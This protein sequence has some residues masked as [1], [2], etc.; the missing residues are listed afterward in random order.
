MAKVKTITRK[1]KTPSVWKGSM[2]MENAYSSGLAG[3]KTLQA[4]KNDGVFLATR[5]DA[6]DIIYFPA[7]LYCERCFSR[8][9]ET[10]K[11]IGP[12]G[13]VESWSRVAIDQKGKKLSKPYHAVLIRLDGANTLLLHRL[14]MPTEPYFGLK[15]RPV[16]KE[17]DKR[18][19]SITDILCFKPL[20][21]N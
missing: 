6:C 17:Q 5:C 7:R 16:L 10:D 3:E 18:R 1:H 4:L 13:S 8:I 11:I 12:Y 19:G 21:Q 15:V 14:E 20:P 9:L 2:T